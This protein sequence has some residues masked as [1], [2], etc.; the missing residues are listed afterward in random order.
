M[1]TFSQLIQELVPDYLAARKEEVGKMMELLA[2]SDFERLRVLSHSLKGSGAS[3]GFAELT[4]IGGTLE[5]Y[6]EA[7]DAESFARELASLKNYLEQTDRAPEANK[8]A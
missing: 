8:D 4:R 1:K 6:A 3:F 5:R 2:A 7:S